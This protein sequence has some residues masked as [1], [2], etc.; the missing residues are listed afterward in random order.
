[1]KFEV[2]LSLLAFSQKS[3]QLGDEFRLCK[4]DMIVL[5]SSQTVSSLSFF[6]SRFFN[7]LK[8]LQLQWR[9]TW[10]DLTTNEIKKTGFSSHRPSQQEEDEDDCA[11]LQPSR[12]IENSNVFI[13]W[14]RKRRRRRRLKHWKK[15]KF[16][17]EVW[18]ILFIIFL[19]G[20]RVTRSQKDGNFHEAD[21]DSPE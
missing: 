9:T 7:C 19:M 11:L 16:L 8:L 3:W 2:R 6:S 20:V 10:D 17:T 4:Q 21:T 14:R 18:L 1:M 13:K 5:L 12:S 15:D